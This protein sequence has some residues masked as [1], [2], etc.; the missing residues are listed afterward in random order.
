M[1]IET[2]INNKKIKIGLSP[3]QPKEGDPIIFRVK[4]IDWEGRDGQQIKIDKELENLIDYLDRA[5]FTLPD[6]NLPRL[7]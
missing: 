5:R 3:L 7:V 1:I 4:F 6:L 2:K